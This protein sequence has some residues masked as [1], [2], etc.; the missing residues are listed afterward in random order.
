MTLFAPSPFSSALRQVMRHRKHLL[1]WLAMA[2]GCLPVGAASI[3]YSQARIFHSSTSSRQVDTR[4]G[5]SAALSSN[6]A[7]LGAPYDNIGGQDCGVV[8][9]HDA[10]SGALLQRLENP[11]PFKDSFFGWSVAVSG[12]MV[13]VGVPDDNSEANDAG[14]AYVYNLASS[15]PAV[16]A[17]VLSN[18]LPII[19]DGFGWSVAISGNRVVVGTPKG[20]AGSSDA[21][22]VYVFDLASASPTTPLLQID[23]PNAAATNFGH[24]VAIDGTKVVASA[25]Q[26]IGTGD[27]CQV[28]VFDL[29]SATPAQPVLSL[30]D[31][32]PTTNEHF[33]HAVAIA[34]TKLAVTAPL[35][36]N[37]FVDSGAAYVYDLSSGTPTVPLHTLSNPS[38]ALNDNF[39]SS[40]TMAGSRV[41]IGM[42]LDDQGGED[43]G[44]ACVYDLGSA[45]PTSPVL[46]LANPG[47]SSGDEF[48][49]AVA[50]FGNRL[51][52]AAP[53][54]NVGISSDVGSG[55][56]F[57]LSSA[58]PATPLLTFNN[59]SPSSHEEFG[60]A[61]A[62]SGN[63]AAVG[64]QK[65]DKVASNAGSV[66]LFDLGAAFPEQPWLVIDNPGPSTNDYFGTAVAAAGTKVVISAYQDDTGGNN[67]GT[68]YIYDTTSST[69]GVPIRTLLNPSP[70]LQDQFGNAVAIS[71]NLVVVGCAKNDVGA[72]DAG[73]AYVYD[74]TSATPTMPVLTLDNPAPATDDW[75]GYSVSISGSK[76]VVGAHQNDATGAIDAGSAYVYDLA[77]ATPSLPVLTINN[78]DPTAD[79]EFGYS[80]AISGGKILI[81]CPLDN[82]GAADAGS[83]YLYDLASATPHLPVATLIH[84]D[85][86]ANEYFGTAVALSGT[87]A[88]VGVPEDDVKATDGG[89][90]YVYE[91][92]SATFP[93]PADRL[94]AQN[95]PDNG[96]LGFSVAVDGTNV[97][98]GGPLHDANTS[99]RG[100]AYLF[101][102]DPPVPQMQVEQPP[103]TGLIAGEGSIQFGNV[104][105]NSQ[106]NTQVVTIRNVGT[107]ELQVTGM[108]IEGGNLEDFSAEPVVLPRTLLVDQILQFQV[109]F[110]PVATGTRLTTLKIECNAGGEPFSVALTGLA[111]SSADDT[112]GDG[113]N[114]VAELGLLALGFDWQVNDE[115]LL[116]ILRSGAN[117]LGLYS[118]SQ[119]ETM[120]QG[121]PV[122]SVNPGT[123]RYRVTLPMEKS[124]DL[125]DFDLFP[126]QAPTVTINGQ[127][128]LNFDLVP[129]GSKG[130][131]RISP[132]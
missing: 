66:S 118:E 81:G 61:V 109:S 38:S 28:L 104:P 89:C 49:H 44:V 92:S 58:T 78:P 25:L 7:V 9:V 87:R 37:G 34:G 122:I 27:T 101:D 125:M 57:D 14:I 95:Q 5:H 2:A 71:G 15:T 33:G 50:L 43:S 115:E 97:L 105:V 70:Q 83:A 119:V 98:M 55:Y 65:D 130:F 126:V 110:A 46:T 11:N 117:T 84:S 32:S 111:L 17:F 103:G 91:I 13:V 88:V 76:V 62:L 22:R 73:S 99:G 23:N 19:N 60:F 8:W 74:L 24:A 6:L 106:G 112:D 116:L 39:G 100:V 51:L 4:M 47:A 67:A 96:L 52:V 114:D 40:V 29:A 93:E 102:P 41:A 64:C 77:S 53:D 10:S 94:E 107:S 3:P 113:V 69:P 20:G 75:F 127:G 80:V 82:A 121:A 45:T 54:D 1:P 131:F 56:L 79:D 42:E 12:S 85:A 35:F 86:K 21:G 30:A 31:S 68:V 72:T 63:L 108:S 129:T 128:G 18:P 90:G 36:D 26:E 120:N 48:G 16:P 123:G 59:P 124:V 132:R